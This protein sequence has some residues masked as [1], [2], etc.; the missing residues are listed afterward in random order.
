MEPVAVRRDAKGWP[1]AVW[2]LAGSAPDFEVGERSMPH[3]RPDALG[4]R[5]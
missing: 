1:L 4:R 5:R 3:E 2:E